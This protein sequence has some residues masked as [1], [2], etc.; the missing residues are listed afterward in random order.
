MGIRAHL[1]NSRRNPYSV[2]GSGT[3]ALCPQ[4]SKGP[5]P[6]NLLA[7]QG[8]GANS[9]WWTPI[10]AAARFPLAC[11]SATRLAPGLRACKRRESRNPARPRL[12]PAEEDT[13][14]AHVSA[15]HPEASQAARLPAP[16]VHPRRARDPPGAAPQGPPPSLGLSPS[17]F[18]AVSLPSASRVGRLRGRRM[19]AALRRAGT[20]RRA[21]PIVI[22]S[23]RRDPSEAVRVAYAI[24]RTTGPAVV[25]NR[26]RRRLRAVVRELP[27]EPGDYLISASPG[28]V[29]L[30]YAQLKGHV[31][32]AAGR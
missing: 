5:R 15:Q 27:L 11:R 3:V 19:F 28:A 8:I 31:R 21:G 30:P 20:R 22:T 18:C 24:P 12:G 16:H 26:L 1:D 10:A 29:E 13:S 14:E 23:V 7:A 32:E 25:R 2:R 9:V 17:L 4:A 6:A